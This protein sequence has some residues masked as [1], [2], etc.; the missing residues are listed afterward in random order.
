MTAHTQPRTAREWLES[1]YTERVV[2]RI[3]YR[4]G[5]R[6][7]DLPDLVQD[8][9]LALC[10][11]GSENPVNAA[12]LH[13][14]ATN[15]AVDFLRKRRRAANEERDFAACLAAAPTPDPE[16]SHLLAARVT[17]LPPALKRFFHLRYEMGLSERELARRLRVCRSSTRWLEQRCRRAIRRANP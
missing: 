14:T 10:L 1:P 11:A 15:K 17:T 7:Q 12:W 4:H 16:L 9:R 2:R 3:G 6:W 5:L 8:V 13:R